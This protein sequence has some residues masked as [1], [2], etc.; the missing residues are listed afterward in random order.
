MTFVEKLIKRLYP[1]KIIT[2]RISDLL[3]NLS[4]DKSNNKYIYISI[5]TDTNSRRFCYLTLDELI[6]VYQSCPVSERFI[7]E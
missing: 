6:N 3:D 1:N 4:N 5:E 7:Y 2:H